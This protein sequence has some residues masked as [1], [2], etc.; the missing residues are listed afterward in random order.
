M[1]QSPLTK[2]IKKV[3]PSVVSIVISKSL[4]A[5]E[6]DIPPQ[7]LPSL[8]FGPHLQIP[9]ED[10]DAHGMVKIG[11]GSGFIVDPS[12]IILT[13]RHVIVDSN[14]EYTVITDD[15]KKYKAEALAR[16]PVDDV[17]IIKINGGDLSIVTLG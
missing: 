14:A 10:I 2:T 16:D 13:N 17:A 12:G 3:M 4:E 5:I 1:S 7:L 6:R 15:N 8:P 11:G 9:E